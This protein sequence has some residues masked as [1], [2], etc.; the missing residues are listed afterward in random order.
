V[1]IAPTRDKKE[2]GGLGMHKSLLAVRGTIVFRNLEG[3]RTMSEK[4]EST[5]SVETLSQ[6]GALAIQ[7]G[8]ISELKG[9]MDAIDKTVKDLTHRAVGLIVENNL[10]GGMEQTLENGG[11]GYWVSKSQMCDKAPEDIPN[12]EFDVSY[13]HGTTTSGPRVLI[14]FSFKKKDGNQRYL[15]ICLESLINKSSKPRDQPFVE[16]PKAASST[17]DEPDP[18]PDADKFNNWYNVHVL[19]DETVYALGGFPLSKNRKFWNH[20]YKEMQPAGSGVSFDSDDISVTCSM[21]GDKKSELKIVV[22]E[23]PGA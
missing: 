1:Y 3:D 17:S 5:K 18:G 22:S 19:D 13:W 16:G 21:D 9:D 10:S 15:C 23:A 7:T 6:S 8:K 11:I 14:G 20:L 2:D 12:G 4:T